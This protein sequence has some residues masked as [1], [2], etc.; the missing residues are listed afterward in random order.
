MNSLPVINILY[1]NCFI[2]S[3]KLH[4]STICLS[5][6][7]WLSEK[8]TQTTELQRWSWYIF[9][10]LSHHSRYPPLL[11][12]CMLSPL[13][14]YLDAD[15]LLIELVTRKQVNIFPKMSN[16]S[17]ELWQASVPSLTHKTHKNQK[18]SRTKRRLTLLN[19]R[20]HEIHLQAYFDVIGDYW[21]LWKYL[22]QL[23]N[24]CI[25]GNKGTKYW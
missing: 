13:A 19:H 1:L 9:E 21:Q 20:F 5:S 7:T 6:S 23:Y 25:S 16:I 18:S 2:C 8:K 15:N 14:P 12:I 4:A 17:F 11:T 24:F 3:Y 10:L 22:Y